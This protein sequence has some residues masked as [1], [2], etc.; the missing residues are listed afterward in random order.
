MTCPV[1]TYGQI[2][3]EVTFGSTYHGARFPPS[4]WSRMLLARHRSAGGLHGPL[5]N[6]PPL[7][8][9]HD[10]GP[11]A[12]AW[13]LGVRDPCSWWLVS[14]QMTTLT[15]QLLPTGLFLWPLGY[16]HEMLYNFHSL[17]EE[18]IDSSWDQAYWEF[19]PSP[20]REEHCRGA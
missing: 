19:S 18:K 13:A 1:R 11:E 16:I 6:E 9:P 4:V 20:C 8:Q 15:F 7:R 5:V 10:P 2:A 14:C 12:A 17:F 3:C